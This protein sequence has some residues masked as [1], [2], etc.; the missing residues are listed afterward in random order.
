MAV[1]AQLVAA[2]RARVARAAQGGDS[3]A[4][5]SAEALAE[6]RDLTAFAAGDDPEP[7]YVLGHFHLVRYQI[8]PPG[9][10]EADRA[11]AV[12]WF[13]VLLPWR[14]ELVPDVLL[15]EVERVAPFAGHDAAG[16]HDEA[17]RLLGDPRTAHNLA[18]LNRVVTCSTVRSRQPRTR[19]PSSATTR[20]TCAWP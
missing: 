5:L 3:S 4:V 13:G 14:P 12:R 11:A 6:A 19:I 17:L 16:W 10:D 8:L 18:V 15:S 2:I 9:Q 20:A 1:S 7:A